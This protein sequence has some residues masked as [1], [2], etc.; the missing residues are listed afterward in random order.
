MDSLGKR[1]TYMDFWNFSPEQ[2]EELIAK[3]TEALPALR[4]A[5]K[6]TQEQVA[7]AIGISRQTYCAVELQK[8][9]MSWNTYMSLILFF[10]Y[11]PGSHDVI[12]QLDAFPTQLDDCRLSAVERTMEAPCSEKTD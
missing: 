5:T 3:L 4:G 1:R 11:N 6:A 10:D 9:K 8:Q 12:R 7:N 2:K